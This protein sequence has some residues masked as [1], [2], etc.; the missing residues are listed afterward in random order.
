MIEVEQS[1][2]DKQESR[3]FRR[4]SRSHPPSF[5]D[6]HWVQHPQR[7]PYLQ[8]NG[9]HARSRNS[10]GQGSLRTSYL[11]PPQ[12]QQQT[13]IVED[14]CDPRP[15]KDPITGRRPLFLIGPPQQNEPFLVRSYCR[16]RPK[17]VSTL[18]D[19]LLK[20]VMNR[21]ESSPKKTSAESPNET[22]ADSLSQP[23]DTQPKKV[24]DF[25][26]QTKIH[27]KRESTKPRNVHS[28]IA[29]IED[30]HFYDINIK[31]ELRCME[32]QFKTL[33]KESKETQELFEKLEKERNGN[34]QSEESSKSKLLYNTAYEILIKCS[35]EEV[36]AFPISLSS[37]KQQKEKRK[38]AL[39]H[40]RT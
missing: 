1:N 24:V 38:P 7:N 13:E 33:I 2:A 10:Y 4:D 27:R 9:H 30:M 8:G 40:L 25:Q 21:E 11:A 35:M 34:P 17:R 19:G 5:N 18:K 23:S 31:M 37:Y 12:R 20:T 6:P 39:K 15:R 26:I 3:V 36:E 14:T 16:N 22:S 29:Q 32:H 28:T